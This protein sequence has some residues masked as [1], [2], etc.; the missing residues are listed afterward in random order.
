MYIENSVK[1]DFYTEI[2]LAEG[3][4]VRQLQ[5][6]LNPPFSAGR[7]SNQSRL[8]SPPNWF[9]CRVKFLRDQI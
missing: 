3:R 7:N 8:V 4:S 9:N 5:E 2:A 6:R 1:R